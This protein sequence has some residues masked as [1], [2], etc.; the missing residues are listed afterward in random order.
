MKNSTRPRLSA[1]VGIDSGVVVVGAGVGQNA[2]VSDAAK[3][4][5]ANSME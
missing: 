1:R 5:K 4:T 2:N 3:T